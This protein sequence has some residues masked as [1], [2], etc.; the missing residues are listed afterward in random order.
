MLNTFRWVINSKCLETYYTI[1]PSIEMNEMEPLKEKRNVSCMKMIGP[2]QPQKANSSRKKISKKETYPVSCRAFSVF[3]YRL[4]SEARCAA[5]DII[6]P[7]F[8]SC[9]DLPAAL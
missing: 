3:R 9:I 5:R 4:R 2:C 8:S 6:L 7:M 1:I